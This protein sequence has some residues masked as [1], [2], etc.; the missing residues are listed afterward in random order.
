MRKLFLLIVI[1]AAYFFS[2]TDIQAITV[3]FDTD[4]QGPCDNLVIG[5]V[6]IKSTSGQPTTTLGVGLGNNLVGSGY[7][8][9]RQITFEAGTY[10]VIEDKRE[11][12]TLSVDGFINSITILPHFSILGTDDPVKFGF[13]IRTV[14][15]LMPVY[16]ITGSYETPG[17]D[18]Y[19][20]ITIDIY[21][22]RDWFPSPYV[23][24]I[25]NQANWPNEQHYFGKYLIDHGLGGATIERG[26]TILSIDYT[27]YTV[28]EPATMLLLGLGLI[29]LAGVRRKTQK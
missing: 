20:P 7:S 5:G 19:S 1:L 28:P 23:L 29:G 4:N 21:T 8:V 13:A 12:L 14:G 18:D 11:D 22:P 15:Y 27:P 17:S 10:N 6:T 2:V 16:T 25:D 24:S 9:D 26:F 3:Q